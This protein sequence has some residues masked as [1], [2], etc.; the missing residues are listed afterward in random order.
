LA[1]D[2]TVVAHRDIRNWKKEDSM[3]R[4]LCVGVAA[5]MVAIAAA[6]F[7]AGVQAQKLYRCGNTYQETP[8]TGTQTATKELKAGAPA[9]ASAANANTDAECAQRGT[10][11]QKISW[12][13]ETGATAEKLMADVDAKNESGQKKAAEKQLIEAVY[14]KRGTAPQVRTAIEADCMAEKEKL[15]QAAALAAAAANLKGEAPP[16][17]SQQSAAQAAKNEEAQRA[18]EAKH[19]EEEAAREARRKKAVC[20]SLKE[21]LEDV[22]ARQRKGATAP[23]MADLT[24]R[25]NELESQSSAAGC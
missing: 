22:V 24:R 18:A 17:P 11:S 13:R 1:G 21:Q 3:I 15:R 12:S 20:D 4:T 10:D 14:R 2:A 16:N 7:S 19:K 23:Q 6:T 8:C 25:K 9:S 5:A